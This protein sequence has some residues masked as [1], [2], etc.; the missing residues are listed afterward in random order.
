MITILFVLAVVS[1]GYSLVATICLG[2]QKTSAVSTSLWAVPWLA[3]TT[4][5]GGA[6]EAGRSGWRVASSSSDA[7][8]FHDLRVTS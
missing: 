1:C 5:P 6:V 7:D 4:L 8:G 2:L 3:H